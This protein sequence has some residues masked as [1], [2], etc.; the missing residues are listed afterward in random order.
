MREMVSLWFGHETAPA[1]LTQF[2]T[3]L[4]GHFY[5][6]FEELKCY[7]GTFKQSYSVFVESI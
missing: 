4:T 7:I 5:V 3:I 1:L 2:T 6:F